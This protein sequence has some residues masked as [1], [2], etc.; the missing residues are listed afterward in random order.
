MVW[1]L[2]P[3]ESLPGEQKYFI[4]S[5]GTYKVGR[6]GCDVII[7]TDKGVSRVH[8]EVVVNSMTSLDPLHGNS[9]N[10]SL[11]VHIKDLSK[12]G[13]FINKKQGSKANVHDHP[14][15]ETTL[16]D[17]DLI[18]FGTGNATY[19]FC[20]VPLIF[21]VYRSIPPKVDRSLQEQIS[22]IGASATHNWK[23]GCTHALVDDSAPVEEDLLD[24]IM[25]QKPVI[26][27]K[28]IKVVAEKNISSELPSFADCLP[29]LM[30]EGSPVKVVDPKSRENCLAGYTFL[31]GELYLYTFGEQLQSLLDVAG[32]K[33]LSV[34]GFCSTSQASQDGASNRVVLVI[35]A[36]SENQFNGQQHIRSLPR[37]TDVKLISAILSGQLDPSAV[38]S[39][40]I[41]VSSSC[42]TDETIVADSDVEMDTATTH[43]VTANAH[44]VT[45]KN[46]DEP[47]INVDIAND[48]TIS[49][50]A[51]PPVS[52]A[53]S[54]TSKFQSLSSKVEDGVMIEKMDKD[55]EY[56]TSVVQNSDI[57]YTQDLIVRDT[58]PPA[59]FVS[60]TI[61]GVVN[62]KCFRR[63]ETE[64]GNSYRCLIP[65][66]KNPYRESEYGNE[67]VA[68]HVKEEKKRKQM[69]AISEDLFNND[70]SRRRGAAGTSIRELL[71]RG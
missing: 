57:V 26:L 25:A 49:D 29:T 56:D 67:E 46:E 61:R 15:K 68:E 34:N 69:E 23:S 7:N 2:F 31:F 30:L 66:S 10:F 53:N 50:E 40:P 35:P 41:L 55:D 42:S 59:S 44:L 38:E 17:G 13:T 33:Y 5:K 54:P 48:P 8:A 65:F 6:R 19:R 3:V 32:S 27:N 70:K 22:S 28:W 39:P 12:Y 14:N 63:R 11:D 64:S 60:T 20:F 36:R 45:P 51:M 21:F 58:N 9:S 4:F 52:H 47:T 43:G 71:T 62:F 18:S 37:L 1:G 24:A 16:K